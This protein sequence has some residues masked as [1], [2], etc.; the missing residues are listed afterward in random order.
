[1]CIEG[2]AFLNCFLIASYVLFSLKDPFE[3]NRN[4]GHPVSMPSMLLHRYNYT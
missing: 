3:L 4:L 2:R 1:M